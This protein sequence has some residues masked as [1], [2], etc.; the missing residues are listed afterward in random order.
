MRQS[1]KEKANLGT[2]KELGACNECI[3]VYQGLTQMTCND[4]VAYR[5]VC[6]FRFN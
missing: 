4:L 1:N 2:N 3:D 6:M 5:L